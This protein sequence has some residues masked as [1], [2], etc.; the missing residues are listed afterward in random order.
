MVPID[1]QIIN[2]RVEHIRENL[3]HLREYAKMSRAAFVKDYRNVAAAERMLQT[4]IEAM[5]DIGNH[6]IATESFESPMEYKDVFLILGRHGI[7]SEAFT[8]HLVEMAKFRNL[9]VHGY[10]GVESGRVFEIIKNNL[11][12]FDRFIKIILGR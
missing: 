4:S 9:I 1:K 12:D 8:K 6:I 3:R 10:L 5:I 11:R 2:V 7:F